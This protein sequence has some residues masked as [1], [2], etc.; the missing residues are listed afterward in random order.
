MNSTRLLYQA[1]GQPPVP[2][3]IDVSGWMQLSKRKR[4]TAPPGGKCYLCGGEVEGAGVPTAERFGETWTAHG[5]ALQPDAEW[6]CAACAFSL[7]EA[8]THPAKPNPFKMRT[9]THLVVGSQWELLGLSDKRRMAEVLLS[10]PRADPWLLCIQDAPL[11]A[12]HAIYRTPVNAAGATA[13]RVTLGGSV[14]AGSPTHLAAVL[15]PIE[16]LYL[17]EHSKT[18][19]R[20]GVYTPKWI[21]AQGENDWARL[22]ASIALHRGRPLFELALFLVQ[23]GI[24]E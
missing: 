24:E 4:P 19:I 14:I 17:A 3:V 7:S 10:P 1:A 9:M 2:A 8:A 22:E 12:G 13:W 20:T 5:D 18:A 15:T 21:L 23:K 11:S 6:L 16:A